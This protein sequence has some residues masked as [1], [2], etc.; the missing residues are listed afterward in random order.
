MPMD[1]VVFLEFLKN[2]FKMNAK[3]SLSALL[4]QSKSFKS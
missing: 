2:L 1:Y 4:L 3:M